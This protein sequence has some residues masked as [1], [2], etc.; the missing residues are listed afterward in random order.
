M[1]GR[2][3]FWASEQDI[4]QRRRIFRNAKDMEF[5]LQIKPSAQVLLYERAS[6][7]AIVLV[8]DASSP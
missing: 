2:L 1:A 5:L 6:C 8:L 4:P 3:F 7:E